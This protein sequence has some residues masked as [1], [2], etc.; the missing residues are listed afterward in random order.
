MSLHKLREFTNSIMKSTGIESPIIEMII[1][2]EYFDFL[3]RD[4]I[5][6]NR[7]CSDKKS[8]AIIDINSLVFQ[9]VLYKKDRSKE[10]RL[11]EDE[12]VK[13]QKCLD[14]INDKEPK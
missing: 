11:L 1:K 13:L 10:K 14:K 5:D 12:I 4:A 2:E 8:H 7:F 3:L 9:G 6:L